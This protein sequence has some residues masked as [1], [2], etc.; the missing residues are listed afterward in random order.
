MSQWS[1]DL[2]SSYNFF[3]NTSSLFMN[4]YPP[5]F[6]KVVLLLSYLLYTSVFASSFYPPD[7]SHKSEPQSPS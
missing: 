3:V 1:W 5:E 7:V 6:S 2:I 4:E